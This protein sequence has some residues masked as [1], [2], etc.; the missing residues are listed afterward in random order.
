MSL[1]RQF[2]TSYVQV[3]ARTQN[4]RS[5]GMGMQIS[6]S[7]NSQIISLIRDTSLGSASDE[8]TKDMDQNLNKTPPA[9]VTYGQGYTSLQQT[10][11]ASKLNAS[12]ALDASRSTAAGGTG[13]YGLPWSTIS[14]AKTNSEGKTLGDYT[15][16]GRAV[17]PAD[18]LS[19][20]DEALFA[21]VTGSTIKDG[22]VYKADGTIDDT[23]GSLDFVN[24]LYEMR[25]YGVVDGGGN[26]YALGG[27]ITADDMKNYIANYMAGHPT[28]A[29]TDVLT[30]GLNALT[31][32]G[33][34]V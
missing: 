18:W 10:L 19:G 1:D 7:Y 32:T 12:S 13:V 30:K 24:D 16:S 11:S 34:S 26:R 17:N 33:A 20:S 25:N 31:D 3:A 28:E 29:E 22:V 5:G 2:P 27:D 14:P 21:K 4:A 9:P 23:Q 15:D 6:S 8:K